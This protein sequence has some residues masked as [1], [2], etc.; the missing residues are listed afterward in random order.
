MQSYPGGKAMPDSLQNYR[1]IRG[2]AYN[3]P[4]SLAT[5]WFRGY[6]RPATARDELSLTGFRCVMPRR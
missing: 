1:V 6:N 2:G 5:A 4:A 3:T